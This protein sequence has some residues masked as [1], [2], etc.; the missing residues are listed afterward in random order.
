[1]PAAGNYGRI[2]IFCQ[3]ETIPGM[4]KI[5]KSVYYDNRVTLHKKFNNRKKTLS[6]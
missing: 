2:A 3:N 6:I 1:M 4:K 5:S